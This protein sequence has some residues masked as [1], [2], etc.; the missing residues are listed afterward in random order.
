MHVFA[1]KSSDTNC[2]ASGSCQQLELAPPPWQPFFL[3]KSY[4]YRGEQCISPLFLSGCSFGFSIHQ[5][6]LLRSNSTSQQWSPDC[7]QRPLDKLVVLNSYLWRDGAAI[8]VLVITHHPAMSSP[9]VLTPDQ[10]QMMRLWRDN[11]RQRSLASRQWK[12]PG[13]FYNQ[14]HFWPNFT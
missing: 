5:Q 9:P 12:P 13:Q 7:K 3:V 11:D 2:F 14:S 8:E 4:P 10:G 1:E 6:H